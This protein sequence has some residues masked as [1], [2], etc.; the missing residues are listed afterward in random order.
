MQLLL[1]GDLEIIHLHFRG[2]VWAVSSTH[3]RLKVHLTLEVLILAV[4]EPAETVV[5]LAEPWRRL[6][7]RDFFDIFDRI[8]CKVDPQGLLTGACCDDTRAHVDAVQTFERF[9]LA[10]AQLRIQV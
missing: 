7:P 3:F 10:Y 8:E 9:L 2:A 1:L 4:G 5:D 6:F